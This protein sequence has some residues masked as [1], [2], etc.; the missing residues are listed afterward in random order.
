M[1]CQKQRVQPLT[2]PNKLGQSTINLKGI[3]PNQH[4][5]TPKE[6]TDHQPGTGFYSAYLALT[7]STL[8]SSQDSLTHRTR[9]NIPAWGNP[10]YSSPSSQPSQLG[11]SDQLPLTCS[12]TRP[13]G[14]GHAAKQWLVPKGRPPDPSPASRSPQGFANFTPPG[15]GRKSGEDGGSI[16]PRLPW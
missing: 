1:S 5:T 2:E 13:S 16:K 14:E 8:L 9:T 6:M 10:T 7:L 4:P 11:F 15:R 12:T 3:R